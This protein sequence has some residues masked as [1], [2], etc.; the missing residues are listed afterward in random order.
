[1]TMKQQHAEAPQSRPPS[2]FDLAARGAAGLHIPIPRMET[3]LP[4]A[5]ADRLDDV[6]FGEHREPGI[7]PAIVDALREL[8][9]VAPSESLRG[10]ALG[11]MYAYLNLA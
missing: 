8:Y 2:L 1:M 4:R 6:G 5:W 3:V 9:I 7:D 10:L 11:L